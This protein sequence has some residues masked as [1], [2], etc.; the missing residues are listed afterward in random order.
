MLFSKILNR[1]FLYDWMTAHILTCGPEVLRT[2]D[3]N[4]LRR[5]GIIINLLHEQIINNVRRLSPDIG[6]FKL[7]S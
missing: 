5:Y 1:R 7:C 4:G 2:S 6:G 3:L